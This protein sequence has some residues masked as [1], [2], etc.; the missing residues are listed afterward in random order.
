MF[1]RRIGGG[2]LLAGLAWVQIACG[3]SDRR[4]D[5]VLVI[6]D[7]VRADHLSAY[8]YLRETT[9]NLDRLAAEGERYDDAWAQAP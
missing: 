6:L 9:P 3:L 8:G 2:L 7:T 1:A 4:G 5:V